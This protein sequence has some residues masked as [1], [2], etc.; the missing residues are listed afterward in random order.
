VLYVSAGA[1][2]N[3]SGGL[4]LSSELGLLVGSELGLF[5]SGAGR[6]GSTEG[7]LPGVSLGD[8]VGI[9]LPSVLGALLG[10]SLTVGYEL[11]IVEESCDGAVEGSF[12]AVGTSLG[13]LLGVELGAAMV[14]PV[15]EEDGPEL[16]SRLGTVDGVSVFSPLWSAGPA[17][18]VEGWLLGG[19]VGTSSELGEEL[20][21]GEVG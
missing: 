3:P 16:G 9:K 6:E 13:S 14:A 10:A 4:E 15:G 21:C 19:A 11:F 2:V 1:P 17:G 8:V 7:L 20:G 18:P 12:I 5:V